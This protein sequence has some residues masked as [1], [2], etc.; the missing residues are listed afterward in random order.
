MPSKGLGITPQSDTEST[1]RL[2]FHWTPKLQ[3]HI[4]AKGNGKGKQKG[5]DL[6]AWKRKIDL[7]KGQ[8]QE[9]CTS[10]SRWGPL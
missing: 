10:P 8:G 2:Q 5:R 6:P 4:A 9:L 1:I 3:R 7:D